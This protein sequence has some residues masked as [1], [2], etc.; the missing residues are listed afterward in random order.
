MCAVMVSVCRQGSVRN[1]IHSALNIGTS[2]SSF[3]VGFFPPVSK[4]CPFDHVA[5]VQPT[6]DETAKAGLA[7]NM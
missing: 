2:R 5:F 7:L 4:F 1:G 6:K 3:R